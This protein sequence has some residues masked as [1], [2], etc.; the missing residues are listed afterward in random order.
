METE[1]HVTPTTCDILEEF[2][3][4][5]DE[6]RGERWGD[7]GGGVADEGEE[8]GLTPMANQIHLLMDSAPITPDG[9]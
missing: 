4:A 3:A 5:L 8:A 9:E 1:G 7:G 2:V 6:G